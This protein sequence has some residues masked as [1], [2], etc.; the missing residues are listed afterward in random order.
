MALLFYPRYMAQIAARASRS[1]SRVGF[2]S[3]F[4]FVLKVKYIVSLGSGLRVMGTY[5]GTQNSATMDWTCFVDGVNL[6]KGSPNANTNFYENHMMLC[7]VPVSD[8]PHTLT[9]SAS[10]GSNQ[11]LW[12]DKIQYLPSA[13]VSLENKTIQL[14]GADS[15]I[16]YGFGWS[17]YQTQTSDSQLACRFYG[18]RNQFY[19]T[20]CS[21]CFSRSFGELVWH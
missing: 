15:A 4:S 20:A 7:E 11:T 1:I 12:L 5:T 19:L 21:S 9:V 10:V 6:H 16:T 2:F 3:P 18:M 17:S 8:G 13:S 14:D